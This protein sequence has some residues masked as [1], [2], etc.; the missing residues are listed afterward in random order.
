MSR[1]LL[2]GILGWTFR[3]GAI[4]PPCPEEAPISESAVKVSGESYTGSLGY[5]DQYANG[6]CC[7]GVNPFSDALRAQAD[8]IRAVARARLDMAMAG[9][10]DAKAAQEWARARRLDLLVK[11]LRMELYNLTHDEGSIRRQAAWLV[12]QGCPIHR[13]KLGKYDR[14]VRDAVS[15]VIL[16]A[17]QA[18]ALAKAY[19]VPVP[20]IDAALFAPNTKG[21]AGAG[22]PGGTMGEYLA[23]LSDHDYSVRPGTLAHMYLLG[24]LDTLSKSSVEEILRHRK[25]LQEIRMNVYSVWD[26]SFYKYTLGELRSASGMRNP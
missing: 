24:F 19:A 7:G 11:R 18:D 9:L 23:F 25:Y 20:E 4:S 12:S 1:W 14:P 5:Y 26:L 8:Y 3:A 6:T 13:I 22:F 2:L 15:F 16:K 17:V 10:T 21:Q